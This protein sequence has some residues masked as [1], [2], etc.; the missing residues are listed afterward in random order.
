[1][2]KVFNAIIVGAGPAGSSAAI[3]L[4]RAG[5]SV[6]LVEKQNF[7][8]RKVC[9]ECISASNFPLLAALGIGGDLKDCV[10][11]ELQ[12]VALMRGDRIVESEL[13]ANDHD[14][15]RWGHALNRE[16]LDTL[17]LSQ[18]RAEGA[19]I[20]QPWSVRA[21]QG[22]AGDWRCDLVD[23]ETGEA[24]RLAAPVVIDAHGSW[25]ALASD[26]WTG[27]RTHQASDLLAFK[28]TF[29][30]A[31][32]E[33]GL[34]TVLAFEGGYGGM[35]VGADGVTTVACCIRRDRLAICRLSMPGLSA[36]DAVEALLK[37]Q[38]R[39]VRINLR[40]ATRTSSWMAAGPIMPG[41]FLNKTEGLFRIGNAAGEA[42]P[43]VGEG[44]SM[45][46]QSP[47]LLCKHLLGPGRSGGLAD[48][49]WQREVARRYSRDWKRHFLPRFR[50]A[51]LFAHMAMRP[52]AS[53]LLL[54]VVR[55]WP[56]V[57]N[58]G[59]IW[60]GK[61]RCAAS[62]ALISALGRYAELDA[63]P[64]EIDTFTWRHSEL[65]PKEIR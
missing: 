61:V 11:P 37:A 28:A 20:F 6:A 48:A 42:H 30:N 50:I 56:C 54:G 3:L 9:G 65:E 17:L 49:A 23:T 43:I 15:Y 7:P 51:A 52:N 35:V 44:I 8:R 58:R 31:K 34:L 21:M 39:G 19:H 57:L 29:R 26:R 64:T 4:A 33:S 47:W 2:Q 18:A 27:Q 41:V 45:A 60:S 59:A 63:T 22:R 10:G 24:I 12:K 40:G 55:R 32:V 14:A 5:W 53:S 38:C 62:P 36:G 1:M 16:S 25:E 13:P 46:L